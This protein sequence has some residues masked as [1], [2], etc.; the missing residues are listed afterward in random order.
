MGEFIHQ[1]R[2]EPLHCAKLKEKTWTLASGSY[3]VTF[4]G[5]LN[6]DPYHEQQSSFAE[7]STEHTP[8]LKNSPLS[9]SKYTKVIDIEYKLT[10]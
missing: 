7:Q 2:D 9:S 5:Y 10:Q 8:E 1:S 6:K 4:F 3:K